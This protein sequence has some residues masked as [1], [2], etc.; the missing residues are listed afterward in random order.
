[1]RLSSLIQNVIK[2][3]VSNLIGENCVVLLFGSRVDDNQRGG[4][5]DLLIESPIPIKN[6][7]ELECKLAARLYIKLGGR[8]VDVLIKDSLTHIKPIHQQAIQQGVM[9]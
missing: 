2:T 4:D 8:K 9:L 6:R 5:I 1:M 3:E 7:V